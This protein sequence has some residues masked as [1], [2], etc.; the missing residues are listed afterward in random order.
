[1]HRNIIQ[2]V[3]SNSVSSTTILWR[4]YSTILKSFR[5]ADFFGASA[6]LLKVLA[7][8]FGTTVSHVWEILVKQQMIDSITTIAMIVAMAIICILS[9]IVLV[10]AKKYSDVIERK[11]ETG[12]YSIEGME[13]RIC[14]ERKASPSEIAINVGIVTGKQIGRAHV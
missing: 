12:D 1:M 14:I 6:Y 13:D 3:K 7:D 8:Q 5:A 10:R 9:I 11:L 4:M 2:T